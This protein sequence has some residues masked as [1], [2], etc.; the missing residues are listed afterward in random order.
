M[1]KVLFDGVFFA[2]LA[3]QIQNLIHHIVAL[4]KYF[5]GFCVQCFVDKTKNLSLSCCPEKLFREK[6]QFRS[7]AAKSGG[8]TFEK[9]MTK[10]F[11]RQN[12][13]LFYPAERT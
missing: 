12:L 8:C 11:I 3:P 5:Y 4:Q 13:Y 6:I 1:H 7:T 9:K 10:S 2:N